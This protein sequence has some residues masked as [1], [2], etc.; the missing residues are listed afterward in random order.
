MSCR[1]LPEFGRISARLAKAAPVC[2]AGPT[3]RSALPAGTGRAIAGCK[4]FSPVTVK[5]TSPSATVLPD[6]GRP[7]AVPFSRTLAN[8]L[9][10]W[11][12]IPGTKQRIG[13]DPIIGLIPGVGDAIAAVLGGLI[14]ME[15]RQCGAPGSVMRRMTANLLINAFVGAVPL[16]GDLFSIWY[17]SNAR[18]YAILRTWQ[19]GE[20]VP[21]NPKTKWLAGGCIGLLAVAIGVGALAVWLG[22]TLW[23]WLTS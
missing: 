20:K 18:N 23:H 3:R 14:L 21:A 8:L 2:S 19:A 12:R 13:F 11:F 10:T 7:A 15:A 4:T 22:R 5:A 6:P 16:L 17:Q 1:H 9:D